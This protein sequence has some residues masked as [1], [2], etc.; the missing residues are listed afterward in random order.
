MSVERHVYFFGNG[1]AD[2]SA[3]MRDILGGK[4]AGL[5]EMA[6]L[7]LPVLPASPSPPD[8]ASL[9]SRKADSRRRCAR[10]STGTSSISSG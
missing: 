1:R 5:A 8:C 9:T 10:K 4:G 6:N 2:G 7:G 3:A